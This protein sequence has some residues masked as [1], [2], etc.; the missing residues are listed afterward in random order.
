MEVA[1]RVE[2]VAATSPRAMR[3]DWSRG[4]L[5]S[6][7]LGA[8]LAAFSIASAL[9]AFLPLD[10]PLAY[11]VGAHV[12]VPLWGALTCVLPLARD[13]RTAWAYCALAIVPSALGLLVRSLA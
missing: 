9:I 12:F 8:P 4:K 1:A 10:A 2:P 5:W 13:A 3:R 6:A 11:A 7:L